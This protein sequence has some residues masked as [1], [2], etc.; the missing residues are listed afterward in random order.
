VKVI[1]VLPAQFH[2]PGLDIGL[3][4]PFGNVSDPR[5]LS[6]ESPGAL[7]RVPE[8]VALSD[9]KRELQA[10]VN[11]SGGFSANVILDVLSLKD[12]R[13]QTWEAYA[14]F[15]G[16]ALLL[17]VILS[18]SSIMWLRASGPHRNVN[19]S[20]RWWLFFA[21]KSGLLLL[22]VAAASLDLVQLAVLRLGLNTTDY[23]GGAVMWLWS[24]G[25]TIALTWSIHDQLSRCRA[26]LCRLRI[27][28]DLGNSFG[29]FCEPGG[30][31]LV[32]D[33][34]HGVLHLPIMAYSCLDSAR[35]INLDESWQALSGA[36]ATTSV[37]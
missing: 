27:Q 14:G 19:D 16:N 5:L 34:G 23:A 13:Y 20:F 24:V 30:S 26:C 15:A 37:S 33:G 17:F 22:I 32:C 4:T 25:L 9:A 35:W 21:V 11:H 31:E 1:G 18:W 8:G 10:Y 28:V 3:Y 36:Q 29:T 6:F 2:F 7:L 12:I